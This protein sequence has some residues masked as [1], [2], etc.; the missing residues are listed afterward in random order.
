MSEKTMLPAQ[1]ITPPAFIPAHNAILQRTCACGGNPG[2]SGECE[3]CRQKRLVSQ[4]PLIQPKLAIGQPN[5][6][7]EQ[8][9]DRMADTVMRMP[10]PKV[11][12]QPQEEVKEDD[13]EEAV[14]TKPIAGQITPLVQRQPEEDSEQDDEDEAVQAKPIAGQVTPL[15]QRQPADEEADEEEPIQAKATPSHSPQVTSGFETS[16]NAMKGGGRPL[17]PATRAYMEPRFGHDFSQVRVHTDARAAQSAQSIRALAYTVGNSIVFNAGQYAPGT[18]AGHKLMAHELTHVVQQRQNIVLPKRF[19]PKRKKPAFQTAAPAAA[20]KQAPVE[21]N[22]LWWLKFGAGILGGI[23]SGIKQAVLDY[24]NL[25]PDLFNLIR[26]LV[27]NPKS[28]IEGFSLEALLAEASGL[29]ENL[30]N[31]KAWLAGVQLGE[32]IG[33]ILVEVVVALFTGGAATAA[34]MGVRMG[35]KAAKVA[36]KMGK[37]LNI[38]QK[39]KRAEKFKSIKKA[40]TSNKIVKKIFEKKPKTKHSQKKGRKETKREEKQKTL[41][42]CPPPVFT[43]GGTLKR[44]VINVIV[45]Q[46]PHPLSFLLTGGK[47]KP[48]GVKGQTHADYANSLDLIQVGH[49]KSKKAG[50]RVVVI[51]D[52]WLNQIDDQTVERHEGAFMKRKAVNLFCVPVEWRTAMQW[53]DAGYVS[54]ESVESAPGYPR[55]FGSNPP[56]NKKRRKK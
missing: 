26:Q 56:R 28:L 45:S 44:H 48:T 49:L 13:Q 1:K 3:A 9:A 41:P 31:P 19:N 21:R 18:H 11:Q 52:A 6:K 17:D 39:L 24:I 5:D 8:E 34:K 30:K 33:S 10:E 29:W 36:A 51:Q 35:V 38:A 20:E 42:T 23:L 4:A 12:R 53:V 43:S 40:I 15:V 46:V 14:Q 47:F 50:G 16:V 37:T 55:P 27:T 7:Y 32:I 25:I 22:F 2:P 54:K